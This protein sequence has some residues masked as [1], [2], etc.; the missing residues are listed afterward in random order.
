MTKKLKFFIWLVFRDR[1][2]SKNLLK[3][4]NFVIEGDDYSC[5]LCSTGVEELT[6]HLLFQ[7]PFAE[8]CWDLLNIHWDHNIPFFDTIQKSKSEWPFGYFMETFA[9]ATWEIWKIR[10]N[11]IFRGDPLSFHA[12]K[13]NF[14]VSVKLQLFRLSTETQCP[15]LS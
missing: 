6:Y 2:N 3:R 14:S 15:V 13:M 11:K 9:I 12:W 8:R 10:N 7:C 4:K 1:I 5:V